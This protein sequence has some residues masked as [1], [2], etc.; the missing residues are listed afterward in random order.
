MSATTKSISM[1]KYDSAKWIGAIPFVILGLLWFFAPDI[2]DYPAYK[3]PSPAQVLNVIQ[4]MLLD[5]S[6][7]SHV[8]D[9]LSLLALGYVIGNAIAIPLGLLI[10]LNRRVAETLMPILS[11]FQSIAGIAWVPLAVIWFG[12]GFGSVVFVIANTIFFASIYSTVVGVQSIQG[13]LYRAALTSGASRWDIVR[14]VVV[15]GALVQ[16]IVGL[17]TS[18]AYGWRAMVAAEMIAGTSGIG[19]IA[20]EAVQW[21]QTEIVVM[22]MLLIGVLWLLLDRFIFMPIETVTVR[23]WG[24]LSD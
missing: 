14:D 3:L 9:S 22:S 15:P 7:L 24:M 5:G 8:G 11:F 6:L 12:I 18:M 1:R 17:R 10:A 13:V 2:W 19:Y 23:R 4:K 16:I 21:Y 20:L